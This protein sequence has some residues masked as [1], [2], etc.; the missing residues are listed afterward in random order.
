MNESKSNYT[1]ALEVLAGKW[2]NGVE[3][4]NKL[5]AAGYS[6]DDV[7]TI[8]NSLVKDGYLKNPPAEQPKQ[9]EPA[10]PV[11]PLEIDYNP[12]EH[13]GIIVNIIV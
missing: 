1:V 7:Q 12:E 5:T 8:V 6:F 9:A 3:R 10:E 11:K 4:R 2:G 13:D